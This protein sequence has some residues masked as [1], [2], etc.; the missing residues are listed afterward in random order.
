MANENKKFEREFKEEVSE[1][2][3]TTVQKID[4]D[5]Y[6]RFQREFEFF[7]EQQRMELMDEV[8][9][10]EPGIANQNNA[11]RCLHNAFLVLSVNGC[12]KLAFEMLQLMPI[13]STLNESANIYAKVKEREMRSAAAKKEQASTKTWLSRLLRILGLCTRMLVGLVWLRK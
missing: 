5:M 2:M 8:R 1:L 4:L 11:V 13:V 6:K 3:R 9:S 7:T 10:F 12:N